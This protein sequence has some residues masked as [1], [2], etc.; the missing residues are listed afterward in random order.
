MNYPQAIYDLIKAFSELPNVGPKT[1]ERYVFYLL[2]NNDSQ[3]FN[4]SKNI[5]QLKERIKTC[6]RC[7]TFSENNICSICQDSN[8]KTETLCIVEN[9]QDLY[10][11]EST[12]EFKGKYFVLGDLINTIEGIMPENLPI[13][14]LLELIKTENTKEIILALNFSMEGE[15]TSLYLK[16]FFK[17]INVSRLAKGLPLGSDLEYADSLSLSNALKYRQKL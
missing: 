13:K 8:R 2:K 11:I 1:A 6:S 15:T 12:N 3:L 4:L 16:K 14:K 7:R 10:S 9:T 17:D 5:I